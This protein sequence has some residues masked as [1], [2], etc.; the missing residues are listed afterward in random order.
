MNTN[1]AILDFAV[2]I[3]VCGILGILII[4]RKWFGTEAL[5]FALGLL[6]L[7]RKEST[8]NCEVFSV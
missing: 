5:L 8:K 1:Y 2:E 4:K 3:S 7:R 6:C